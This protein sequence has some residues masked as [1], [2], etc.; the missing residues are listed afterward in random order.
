MS[1]ACA[2]EPQSKSSSFEEIARLSYSNESVFDLPRGYLFLQS[3]LDARMFGG[4]VYW[5]SPPDEREDL[6]MNQSVVSAYRALNEAQNAIARADS[7]DEALQEGLKVILTQCGAE[8]G[9]IDCVAYV[10]KD[11]FDAKVFSEGAT[12]VYVRCPSLD[13]LNTFTTEYREAIAPIVT[14]LEDLGAERAPAQYQKVHDEA[15]SKL[16]DAEGQI[17]DAQKQ[18]EEGKQ[19]IEEGEQKLE[20]GRLQIEDGEKQLIEGIE[21]ASNEQQEAQQQ[22]NDAYRQLVEGQAQYDAGLQ[23]Y[24]TAMD[25]LGQMNNQFNAVRGEY[26]LL[27]SGVDVAQ[28]FINNLRA[29]LSELD[30]AVDAYVADPI[31]ENWARVE[32][33]YGDVYGGVQDLSNKMGEVRNS[34]NTV[35]SALGVPLNTDGYDGLGIPASVDP[36]TIDS[37]RSDVRRLLDDAQTTLDRVRN[38][39]ISVNGTTIALM[40]LPGGIQG[41]YETLAETEATL[42][43][44]RAQLEAGWAEYNDGKAQ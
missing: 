4:M 29:R 7:L 32:A 5:H 27:V 25:A 2:K 20:E 36:Q 38:A 44:S 24:N 41:L 34:G 14:A 31:E 42:E 19:Q 16:T 39:S 12:N 21:S 37:V 22:L 18:I 40:D 6:P 15:Q 8:A 30:G 10:T 1:P 23:T 17:A 13:G 35:S 43:S 11:A 26:D 3:L 9:A 28:G 33:A